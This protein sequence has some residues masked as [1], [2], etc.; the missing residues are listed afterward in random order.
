MLGSGTAASSS[1]GGHELG[2]KATLRLSVALSPDT[3]PEATGMP[4]PS[5]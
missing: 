2:G 3:M 1:V 5:V 4:H